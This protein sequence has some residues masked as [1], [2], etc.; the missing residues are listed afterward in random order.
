MINVTVV[1]GKSNIHWKIGSMLMYNSAK[2]H[3][4]NK[5]NNAFL[6]NIPFNLF[7]NS[8]RGIIDGLSVA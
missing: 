8:G 3:Y 7:D 5:F 1:S 4:W 2:F 6:S